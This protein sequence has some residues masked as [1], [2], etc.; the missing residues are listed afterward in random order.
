MPPSGQMVPE[1]AATAAGLPRT[2]RL[3]DTIAQAPSGLRP[4]RMHRAQPA[5]LSKAL[6]RMHELCP[7]NPKLLE[8]ATLMSICNRMCSNEVQVAFGKSLQQASAQTL[9][10]ATRERVPRGGWLTTVKCCNTQDAGCAA[11]DAVSQ[12]AP[13]VNAC[14]ALPGDPLCV[15]Q[16]EDW[17]CKR[18]ESGSRGW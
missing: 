11:F 10:D 1:Q 16:P 3:A 7:P 8:S 15:K 9:E 18:G 13:S 5:Q 6:N 2:E 17:A 12:M 14:S 4:Q